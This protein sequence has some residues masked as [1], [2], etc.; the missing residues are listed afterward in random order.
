MEE[1]NEKS[2]IKLHSVS[3]CLCFS[4]LGT[5]LGSFFF[6]GGIDNAC[7]FVKLPS[8]CL[9]KEVCETNCTQIKSCSINCKN[10]GFCQNNV[11][12]CSTGFYGSFC[13]LTDPIV[14]KTNTYNISNSSF[15]NNTDFTNTTTHINY[16][17]PRPIL[18]SSKFYTRIKKLKV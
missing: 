13:N 17:V 7:N 11:C 10:N 16:T 2:K 5:G 14:N 9:E 18:N 6:F 15:I 12:I 8:L 4:L 3:I 1:W